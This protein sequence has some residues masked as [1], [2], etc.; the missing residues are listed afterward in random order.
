[1]TRLKAGNP[2]VFLAT[3]QKS[4]EALKRYPY[5]TIIVSLHWQRLAAILSLQKVISDTISWRYDSKTG[6]KTIE[7]FPSFRAM[8][9]LSFR[10]Q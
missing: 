10:L 8:H 4:I 2:Y 6:L 5:V 7:E 9:N 1:M 3:S